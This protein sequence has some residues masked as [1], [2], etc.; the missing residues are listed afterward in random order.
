MSDQQLGSRHAKR[1]VGLALEVFTIALAVYLLLPRI[2]GFNEVGHAIARGSWIAIVL[3]VAFE[4]ASLLAYGELVRVVL[5]SMG[6]ERASAGLIQRTTVVGTSLGRT[7]PGGT[8]TALAVVVNRL[9]RAGLDP[10]K[11][12]AALATSGLLSSFVLALL[13]IPAVV[14]AIAGGQDGSIALGA[15]LAAV[16]MVGFV[17]A[18]VP[19]AHRPEAVGDV[20]E[21]V[22]RRLVP[23]T[24]WHHIDPVL[25]A[26]AAEHAVRGVR[27]L[28]RNP[29]A[30]CIGLGFAAA[31][32][33][34]DIAA[35]TAVAVTVG[36]GTPLTAILLAYIIGQLA[37]AIPL[38][39][40]GVGILESAMI[41]SLVA[42]GAPVA[43]ATATVLGWRLFSYWLPVLAGLGLLPTLPRHRRPSGA[44]EPTP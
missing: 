10:T 44:L 36:R 29:R 11:S 26:R 39:P 18:L 43:A 30:L 33:L 19:A 12:T 28:L 27:D 13:L 15:S 22:L 7:L 9:R 32:W 21:R 25:A 35:L 20:V 6:E 40:G 16:G 8:T 38:T 41:G 4:T 2:A 24:F 3:L 1:V 42:A 23:R 34:F 17:V 31:N 5:R 37:A 14:L